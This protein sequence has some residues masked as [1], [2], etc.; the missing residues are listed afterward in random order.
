M[1]GPARDPGTGVP[2]QRVLRYRDE[3]DSQYLRLRPVDA[4]RIPDAELQD[5]VRAALLG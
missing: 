5:L 3:M 1:S 2:D 4:T